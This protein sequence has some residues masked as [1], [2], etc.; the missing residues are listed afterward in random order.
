[1]FVF[2]SRDQKQREGIELSSEVT[3]TSVNTNQMFEL[4][5]ERVYG[6]HIKVEFPERIRVAIELVYQDPQLLHRV[7]IEETFDG[8]IAI[9]SHILGQFLGIRANSLL[10]NMRQHGF[11][12]IQQRIAGQKRGWS[13][14]VNS[15]VPFNRSATE[16][17]IR[18]LANYAKQAR[19]GDSSITLAVLTEP[20]ASTVQQ[21]H[22]SME[23][24]M[25]DEYC[26]RS[27]FDDEFNST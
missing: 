12:R 5:R 27:W 19:R 24:L 15:I 4:A 23:L 11:K 26:P 7:G 10:K 9:A 3:F 1:M 20:V 13:F 6:Q 18:M 16:E 25:F 2:N 22:E 17:T 21:G 14:W 8:R